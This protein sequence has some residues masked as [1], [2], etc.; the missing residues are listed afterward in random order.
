MAERERE[1]AHD[2]D[3]LRDAAEGLDPVG[4]EVRDGGFELQEL[5]LVLRP[6]RAERL[7]V[8]EGTPPLLCRPL[9]TGAEVVDVAELDVAHLPPLRDREGEREEGDA[10]LGVDR[11]VDGVDDDGRLGLAERALAE[12]LRDEAEL[13]AG[14]VRRL[15]AP[16]D[17]CLRRGV[18][19]GRVVAAD[20]A[21]RDRLA[22]HARR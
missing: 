3:P 20:A 22:G 15:E 11:A 16:D 9:L 13:Q 18:D 4:H 14:L 6:H 21:P 17:R 12:L 10:A 1:R 5:D 7:A 2:A 19:R 8:E